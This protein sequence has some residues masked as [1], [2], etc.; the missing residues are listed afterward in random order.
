MCHTS[1]HAG[2][3]KLL[4]GFNEVLAHNKGGSQQQ[5][6]ENAWHHFVMFIKTGREIC[7]WMDGWI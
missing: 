7:E 1:F 2:L 4:S 3:F 6:E 5:R